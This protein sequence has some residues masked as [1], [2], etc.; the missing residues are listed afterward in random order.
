MLLSFA[1]LPILAQAAQDDP[2]SEARRLIEKLKSDDTS[3]RESAAQGLKKLGRAV[4][5]SLEQAANH[6]DP[7]VAARAKDLL[8]FIDS[9]A[10]HQHSR[11]E[12]SKEPSLTIVRF[13]LDHMD[14]DLLGYT[15]EGA[16]SVTLSLKTER[17]GFTFAIPTLFAIDKLPKGIARYYTCAQKEMSGVGLHREC[18]DEKGKVLSDE[19]LVCNIERITVY[20]Q[21]QP[22]RW[23]EIDKDESMDAQK[24][25]L[26]KALKIDVLYKSSAGEEKVVSKKSGIVQSK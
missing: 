20:R 25:T 3:E 21:S 15:S 6:P 24:G 10:A 13:A 19:L 18:K 14:N 2:A 12:I 4:V 5:P 23:T 8:V 17:R 26:P 22:D 16:I 11:E 1:L 9:A 7:E